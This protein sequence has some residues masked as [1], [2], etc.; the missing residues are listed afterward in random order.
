[1]ARAQNLRDGDTNEVELLEFILG[2]QTFGINVL[3]IEA[4][5][6]YNAD[7]VT[8]IPMAPPAV[9]GTLLFRGR[10]IPLVNLGVKLGIAPRQDAEGDR[11]RVVLVTEFSGATI[12]FVADGVTRIHRL[13][14]SDVN[15]LADMISGRDSEFTGSFNIE[16]REVLIVDVE[17][18]VSE[19]N[20]AARNELAEGDLPHHERE[21]LRPGVRILVAEDSGTVRSLIKETLARGNYTSVETY[22]DGHA[23]FEAVSRIAKEARAA[24]GDIG[25]RLSLVITDIEMPRM[26]GVTFCQRLR[27]ELALADLPVILYSTRATEKTADVCER[28]GANAFITKPQIARLVE[29]IDR[30]ALE[31]PAAA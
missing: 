16:D 17:K 9:A 5:E 6:Q 27:G 2:R 26:D 21:S 31:A 12:G 29:M 14:W 20:P 8:A 24:G 30:L 3:K 25:E 19:Y 15:P 1:M 28:A 11:N 13:K 23:A 18:I 4:I 7:H 22:G 10:T